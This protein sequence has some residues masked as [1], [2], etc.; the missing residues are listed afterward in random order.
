MFIS[1]QKIIEEITVGTGTVPVE[2][3]SVSSIFKKWLDRKKYRTHGTYK[4]SL[5][6]NFKKIGT[7]KKMNVALSV[8]SSRARSKS[9]RHYL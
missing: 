8:L 5:Q 1:A 9:G 2:N 6:K 4:S 3:A 7:L